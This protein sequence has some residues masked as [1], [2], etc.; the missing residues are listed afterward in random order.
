[1]GEFYMYYDLLIALEEK[2]EMDYIKL[3]Y[4]ST[5][6]LEEKGEQRKMIRKKL[7]LVQRNILEAEKMKRRRQAPLKEDQVRSF[8]K[9][10]KH[11]FLTQ[12]KEGYTL[13]SILQFIKEN[14]DNPG[15]HLEQFILKLRYHAKTGKGYFL[16][17]EATSHGTPICLLDKA[18]R[19]LENEAN[20]S[21]KR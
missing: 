12:A 10:V 15:I 7:Y 21:L 4:D 8:K 16:T 20:V 17:L 14:Y 11:E 18:K 3:I 2:L 19:Y 9:E 5:L 13:E 6:S 1:M